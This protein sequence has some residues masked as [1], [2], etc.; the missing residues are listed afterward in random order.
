MIL[1]RLD[2]LS[3]VNSRL[4]SKSWNITASSILKKHPVWIKRQWDSEKIGELYRCVKR[5]TNF[6]LCRLDL[7][8]TCERP[9]NLDFQKVSKLFTRFGTTFTHLRCKCS[10]AWHKNMMKTLLKK[11]G[12]LQY[13]D[14]GKLPVYLKNEN[15]KFCLSS[16]RVLKFGSF[17][18]GRGE[19]ALKQLIR[20]APHLQEIQ[21]V[22]CNSDVQM[23][24][25]RSAKKFN[26]ISSMIIND[27][28]ET[29]VISEFIANPPQLTALT[30]GTVFNRRSGLALKALLIQNAP[31]LKK[32]ELG[33]F[34]KRLDELP[35]FQKLEELTFKIDG[36]RCR[37][38]DNPMSAVISHLSSS[39]FPMLKK[40]RLDNHGGPNDRRN[41]VGLFLERL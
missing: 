27:C 4:V 6:P 32:L 16:L 40:I 7:S 12:Q 34:S 18:E 36:H 31:T 14:L 17:N 22:N 25:L 24:A 21:H 9:D 30:V 5:S 26:L 37:R 38:L 10:V 28:T 13:L 35:V 3:L 39:S 2:T 1:K 15:P 11:T 19:G 33:G 8:I 41:L 23:G 29:R 20:S